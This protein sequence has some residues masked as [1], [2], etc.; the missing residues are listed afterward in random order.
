MKRIK[1]LPMIQKLL[2]AFLLALAL[3]FAPL[4]AVTISRE[5]MLYRGSI[6]VPRTEGST[7]VYEGKVEGMRVAFTVTDQT[8]TVVQGERTFGPYTVREDPTAIPKRNDMARG[9]VGVE[10]RRGEEILFRGGMH[11]SGEVGFLFREDGDLVALYDEYEWNDFAIKDREEPNYGSIIQSVRG[12]ELLHKGSWMTYFGSLGISLLTA[13][14]ILFAD[15]IFR[16][17]LRFQIR[18]AETA[19]PSEWELVSRW[20]IWITLTSVVMAMYVAGLK[21]LS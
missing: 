16:W 20:L 21:F 11:L 13:G 19:E 5:G 4:Y 7:T 10:V 8:V 6:L 1:A 15:E 18:H 2:L 14:L 17:N 9:M 12:P 3:I